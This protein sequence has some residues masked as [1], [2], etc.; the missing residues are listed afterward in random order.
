MNMAK[1]DLICLH[2]LFYGTKWLTR[3]Q[4]VFV[5]FFSTVLQM[6]DWPACNFEHFKP[7]LIFP[8]N[9]SKEKTK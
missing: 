5:C 9:T 8:Q 4:G 2:C 3:K 7:F 6:G 1:E